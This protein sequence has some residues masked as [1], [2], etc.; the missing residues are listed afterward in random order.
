MRFMTM[1][2]GPEGVQPPAE[3]FAAIA[4]LGEDAAAAGVGVDTGGLLP[5]AVG[6]ARIRSSGGKLSFTDGPFT[7]AKELIGGYAFFTVE[8]REQAME[9]ATRF[10][11]L[12]RDLWP[13]WEG[14]TEI[15]QVME[16]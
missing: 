7:E 13:E 14:E 8:S 15:R 12:H 10:M 4:K 16:F 11:E 2:K 1:V 6:A 3:L 9:W 5:S